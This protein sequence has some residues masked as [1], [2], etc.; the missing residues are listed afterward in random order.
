M[1]MIFNSHNF[2]HDVDN[3]AKNLNFCIR[4][5]EQNRYD[6]NVLEHFLMEIQSLEIW[7]EQINKLP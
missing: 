4:P 7:W 2:L 5:Q 3:A 1:N 6:H